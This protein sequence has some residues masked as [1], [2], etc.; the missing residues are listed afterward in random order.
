M[1][2]SLCPAAT[3]Q[4]AA[5]L[6]E[7]KGPRQGHLDV[8]RRGEGLQ[9]VAPRLLE[10]VQLGAVSSSQDRAVL[11]IPSGWSL[12]GQMADVSEMKSL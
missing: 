1:V 5:L 2:D 7:L 9:D 10:G 4:E 12:L 11:V 6:S 3:G 8:E